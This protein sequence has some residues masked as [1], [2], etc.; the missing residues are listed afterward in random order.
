MIQYSQYNKGIQI[1][2]QTTLQYV[3][4]ELNITNQTKYTLVN[5]TNISRLLNDK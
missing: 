5:Q 2:I 3:E 4:V 1:N